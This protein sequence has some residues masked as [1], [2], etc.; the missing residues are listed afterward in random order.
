MA[1]M[2]SAPVLARSWAIPTR[3][4][5]PVKPSPRPAALAVAL[6]LRPTW[7]GESPKTG[8]FRSVSSSAGLMAWR[9]RPAWG[10]CKGLFPIPLGRSWTVEC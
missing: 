1:R 4:L 9:A 8:A 5:W 3:L 2:F 10:R 7:R 6:T